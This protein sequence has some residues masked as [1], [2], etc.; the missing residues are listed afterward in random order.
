VN[1]AKTFLAL[2]AAA[3]LIAVVCA[4]NHDKSHGSRAGQVV[5]KKESAKEKMEN[6]TP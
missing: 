5:A 2:L 1:T 3:F 4:K 6:P